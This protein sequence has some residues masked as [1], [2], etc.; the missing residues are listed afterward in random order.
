[1][2]RGG[3]GVALLR[4]GICAADLLRPLWQVGCLDNGTFTCSPSWFRAASP[5]LRDCGPGECLERHLPGQHR[6]QLRVYYPSIRALV[7]DWLLDS[8]P[9]KP[10][11]TTMGGRMMLFDLAMCCL[12]AA[13]P[14]HA[15]VP[16]ASMAWDPIPRL[17]N[18]QPRCSQAA[19][20]EHAGVHNASTADMAASLAALHEGFAGFQRELRA[21]GW[22]PI[23][24]VLRAG[25]P[26]LRLR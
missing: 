6:V 3:R 7:R 5:F 23:K 16:D 19:W 10:V 9:E 24:V 18:V 1:M 11:L 8:R 2:W 22:D 4:E 17:L 21:A 14:K 13:G 15:G 20:L 12:R 25:E 26:R